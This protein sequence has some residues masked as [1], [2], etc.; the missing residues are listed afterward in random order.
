MR[1]NQPVTQ[2]EFAIPDGATLVSTTDLQSRIT[3]GNPAFITV[4][5]YEKEEL[6]GQ[7]HNIVRHPDMPPEA[8]G[9]CGRR[10]RAAPPGLHW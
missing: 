1:L 5:G 10:F 4:S 3:Y 8:F 6:I 9:T 2:R 7:T